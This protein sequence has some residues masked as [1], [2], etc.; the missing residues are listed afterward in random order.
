VNAT[1][2]RYSL[3]WREVP[4]WLQV[5]VIIAVVN[6]VSFIAVST[7]HGGDA[8]NGYKHAGHYFV[9]AHGGCAEVSRQFWWYS[10]SHGI[11][12]W[13]TQISV[14]VAGFVFVG[15]RVASRLTKR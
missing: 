5:L 7:A 11:A 12:L 1:S 15:R 2:S 10:W 9:C 3:K 8:L 13:I 6:F 14:I 4:L